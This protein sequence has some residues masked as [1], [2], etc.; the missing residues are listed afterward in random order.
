MVIGRKPCREG[1][2]PGAECINDSLGW[3]HGWFFFLCFAPITTLEGEQGQEKS[4]SQSHTKR[5]EAL[6]FSVHN[7][8]N[9]YTRFAFSVYWTASSEAMIH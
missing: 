8:N 2:Q 3:S 9:Y 1:F 5:K 7:K 6:A 4:R